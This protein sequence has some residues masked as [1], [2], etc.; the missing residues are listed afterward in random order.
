MT[1]H[2]LIIIGL[3]YFSNQ[4]FSQSTGI[5][6]FIPAGYAILDSASGDLNKDRLKDYVLILKVDE[7][8]E[9]ADT[10]RPL[11][12]LMGTV[13][14]QYQLLAR[15]DSVVLCKSCGGVF[16]DPYAGITIK[17]NFFSVEHY[18]GSNWRWTRII[19][20]RYDAKTKQFLLHRDAGESFHTS[21]PDKMKLNLHEKEDFGKLP[22][23]KYSYDKAWRE[24][25]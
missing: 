13:R 18:G 16:G 10:T 7:E 23:A 19:T 22:F 1:N 4:T 21:D 2:F 5:T 3:F 9:H 12:L 6:S 14:D 8:E 11:L 15:N 17:N 24:L 25:P 20:F